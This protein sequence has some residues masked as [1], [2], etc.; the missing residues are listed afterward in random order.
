MISKDQQLAGIV[1][2]VR[3]AQHEGFHGS[4]DIRFR[5]GNVYMVYKNQSML[6]ENLLIVEYQEKP[7]CPA[8]KQ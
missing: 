1:S 8:R 6:P 2:Q 5:E 7:K 4:L 3:Q